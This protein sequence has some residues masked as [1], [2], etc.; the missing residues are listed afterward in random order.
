[1][2]KLARC[3]KLPAFEA[4]NRPPGSCLL[5]PRLRHCIIRAH[6]IFHRSDSTLHSCLCDKVEPANHGRLLDWWSKMRRWSSRRQATDH[7]RL[8]VLP[9]RLL[10]RICLKRL[11]K[12]EHQSDTSQHFRECTLLKFLKLR[13]ALPLILV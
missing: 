10:L 5:P 7:H 3:A 4:A 8:D 6:F 1:M 2:A 11:N 12:G 9:P 13:G